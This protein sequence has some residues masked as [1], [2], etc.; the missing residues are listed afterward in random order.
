MLEKG[1]VSP[2][3]HAAYPKVELRQ[4]PPGWKHPK[5]KGQFIPLFSHE[6]SSAPDKQRMPDLSNIPDGKRRICLYD[7]TKGV[8]IINLVVRD[9]PKGRLKL[10]KQL[11]KKNPGEFGS[12]LIQGLV[13]RDAEKGRVGMPFDNVS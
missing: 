3:E 12:L 6:D 5:E 8:P 11:M 13:L 2:Q 4:V 10:V 7:V 9:N 1:P